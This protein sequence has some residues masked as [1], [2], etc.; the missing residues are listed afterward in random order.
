MQPPQPQA[1]R[2]VPLPVIRQAV[3]PS[4]LRDIVLSVV[5]SV[6]TTIVIQRFL[7]KRWR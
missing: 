6:A 1:Q 7:P 5:V 4:L 2:E 3:L